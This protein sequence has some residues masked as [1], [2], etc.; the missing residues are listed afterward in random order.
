MKSKSQDQQFMLRVLELA[1]SQR[2]KTSPD[3]MVGS[4]IVKGRKIISEGYHGAVTTPHAESWAIE[5]A[6]K[7]VKGATLYVNLE[8]CSHYGNNPP[9][10]DNIIRAGIKRVVA[11]MQDPNPLVK[12]KGFKKLR[13]AKIKVEVGP[14]E[15]EARKL[16]EFFIKHITT[17]LP[18]VILKVAATLDGKIAS[19]TG[20]SRWISALESRRYTH[21]L[22]NQVDAILVGIN[23]VIKDDPQLTVRLIRKVKNPVRII[24]DAKCRVPKNARIL[25]TKE[26]PTIVVTSRGAP[27]NKIEALE[28]MGVEVM[29]VKAKNGK[30]DLK[31]L[32]K[33]LGKRKIMSLIIEGGS[34]VFSSALDGKIVDKIVAF[35]APK[36]IGGAKAKTWYEGIG[37]ENMKRSMNL[38]DLIYWI[39]GKDILVEGY[40]K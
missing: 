11:A 38:K 31:G 34:D 24:L 40:L 8:P 12:G 39:S 9:C 30:I 4:V 32:L 17:G 36:L 5:K 3:P 6:G 7:K 37:I 16:N 13:D 28:K 20:D 25:N 14:L 10:V 27:K 1:A 29:M 23:T 22:R 35:I 21:N 33:I 19:S 2:G 26:A 18:F 15:K